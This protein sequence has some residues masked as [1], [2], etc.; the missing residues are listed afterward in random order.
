MTKPA[1]LKDVEFEELPETRVD[2]KQRVA[3]GKALSGQVT[4]F[5][6]YRN[7]HGQIVL[8]PLVSIPAHEAWLFKNTRVSRSVHRG[9]EEAKRGRLV[10][11][12]EDYS[13]ST[14]TDPRL[15]FAGTSVSATRERL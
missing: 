13:R 1:I 6:V 10:K 7:A 3:L 2:A 8:D 11:S 14:P 5:R 15:S 9:L 12:K 4:S